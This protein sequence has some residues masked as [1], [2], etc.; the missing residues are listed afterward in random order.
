MTP[1]VVMKSRP[2]SRGFARSDA[3]GMLAAV[4]GLLVL[5]CNLEA[6]AF[7]I[8]LLIGASGGGGGGSAASSPVDSAVFGLGTHPAGR[9]LGLTLGVGPQIGNPTTGSTTTGSPTISVGG[10]V[11]KSGAHVA[12]AGATE[13]ATRVVAYTQAPSYATLPGTSATNPTT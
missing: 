8:D 9:T 1:G 11:P 12:A 10:A 7:M 4:A 3:I 5:P 13:T 2:S 6:S